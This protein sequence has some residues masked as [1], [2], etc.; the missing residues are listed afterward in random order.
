MCFFVRLDRMGLWVVGLV[1]EEDSK[2]G[3]RGR[4]VDGVVGNFI[5]GVG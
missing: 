4:E 1:F 2:V 3:I 5:R